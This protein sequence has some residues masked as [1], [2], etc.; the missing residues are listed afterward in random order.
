MCQNLCKEFAQ[1]LAEFERG[2]F[3][4]RSW[5]QF[6]MDV[7]GLASKLHSDSF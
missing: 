4:L 2:S 7:K 1:I 6:S 5:K 3:V